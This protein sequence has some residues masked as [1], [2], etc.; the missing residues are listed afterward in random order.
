MEGKARIAVIAVGEA[1][2]SLC[3][4]LEKRGIAVFSGDIASVEELAEKNQPH[5]IALVGIRGAMEVSTLLEDQDRSTSPRVAVIAA[6]RDLSRLW[7]LNRDVVIS[8]LAT[9]MGDK[10]VAGRLDALARQAAKK[11]GENIEAAPAMSLAPRSTADA[12]TTVA[13][14]AVAAIALVK[15]AQN[16]AATKPAVIEV[17]ASETSNDSV[18]ELDSASLESDRPPNPEAPMPSPSLLVARTGLGLDSALSPRQEP[19]KDNEALAS[20]TDPFGGFSGLDTETTA[21][22]DT[23]GLSFPSHSSEKVN[24]QAEKPAP[25]KEEAHTAHIDVAVESAPAVEG[26]ESQAGEGPL[27]KSADE[28]NRDSGPLIDT[29]SLIESL[30]LDTAVSVDASNTSADASP[31]PEEEK[32]P[33]DLDHEPPDSNELTR[34]GKTVLGLGFR[35]PGSKPATDALATSPGLSNVEA[36]FFETEDTPPSGTSQ[37]RVVS[38]LAP[39]RDPAY[40]QAKNPTYQSISPPP[41]ASKAL[42]A[43]FYINSQSQKLETP[44]SN[45]A[46]PE[47]TPTASTPEAASPEAPPGERVAPAVDS[48]PLPSPGATEDKGADAPQAEEAGTPEP[49]PPPKEAESPSSR[50]AT[51]TPVAPPAQFEAPAGALSDEVLQKLLSE[52]EAAAKTCTELVPN[53]KQGVRDP[54]A[55]GSVP[56]QAARKAIVRGDLVAAQTSMCEAAFINPASPAL[57]SLALLYITQN[58]PTEALLW[59]DKA[60]VVR[61]GVRDTLDLRATALTQL[62]KISEARSVWLKSLNIVDEDPGRRKGA[63]DEDVA[64]AKQH[65]RQGDLPRAE[66]RLR[67]AVVLDPK[68]SPALTAL[69][70]VMLKKGRLE[71]AQGLGSYAVSTEPFFP[72]AYVVLADIAKQQNDLGAAQKHLERALQIRPDFWAAKKAMKELTKP[73]P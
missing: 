5:L 30:R 54:A 42:P 15:Q 72:D 62:G 14:Q 37:P 58:A 59:L 41:K 68:N 9:E 61:P 7:G 35:T 39:E 64:L 11:R 1:P 4:E 46:T 71:A 38:P 73:A 56:W 50:G 18:D 21:T 65:L 26:K 32:S 49:T 60:E 70:E 66:R 3:Q 63:A 23:T 6:R 36:K 29:D 69:A 13:P 22:F 20:S 17:N 2:V 34:P 45:V 8:L 25:Q 27:E 48:A 28:E 19:T 47:P 31:P 55:E 40:L 24:A 33:S 51:S 57:E 44:A 67:R 16:A 43:T 10:V 12:F 52:P 53:P